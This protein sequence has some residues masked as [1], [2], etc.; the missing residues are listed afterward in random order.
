M[1]HWWKKKKKNYTNSIQS[2]PRNRRNRNSSKLINKANLPYSQ[3]PINDFDYIL[4]INKD[5]EIT[6]QNSTKSNFEA[7]FKN[8][9]LPY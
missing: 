9:Y 5:T 2:S 4:T 6:Q 7:T 1:E 3:N 8:Q